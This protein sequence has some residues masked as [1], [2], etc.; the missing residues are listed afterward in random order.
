MHGSGA[1][2]ARAWS[3]RWVALIRFFLYL[4]LVGFLFQ[5]MYFGERTE[6]FRPVAALW[7]L[8]SFFLLS[9][10]VMAAGVRWRRVDAALAAAFVLDIANVTGIVA[11]S[12]GFNSVFFSLYLPLIFMASAW[13]P[14]R[15]TAVFPSVATLGLAYL[16]L[17]HLSDMLG[18]SSLSRFFR[19]GALI[20]ARQLEPF[21]VVSTLLIFSVLFFV[22]AYLAGMLGQGLF[23][24]QR[25]N[26]TILETMT[27][28]VAVVGKDG[29]M[30]YVNSE[31]RRI[32][33]AARPGGSF[34]PAAGALFSGGEGTER[35]FFG[36]MPKTEDAVVTLLPPDAPDRPPVEVR[37]SAIR[38]SEGKELDGL[39]FLVI[40]LSLRRRME[41][42]ESGLEKH[43]AIS[44]MAAGLAHEIRNPLASLRGA[45][46]ELGHSFS[47]SGDGEN[48]MLAEVVLTESDRLD[49]VVGR[50]LDFSRESRLRLSKNRL[51][52]LLDEVRTRLSR[53]GDGCSGVAVRVAVL[54][55]P[56]VNCDPDRLLEVFFNLAL[57]ACQLAPRS[58]GM[59]DITLRED[60]RPGRK[61]VE[62]LFED[63]GP[64]FA[65][66][67]RGRLF[68]PFFTGRSGGTGM[69]LAF[70]RK[71]AALHNGTI[72]GPG[73]GARFSVWLPLDLTDDSAV[74]GR[75]AHHGT[76]ILGS[77]L[78]EQ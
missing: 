41:R 75:R 60:D 62:I 57:N 65:E 9:L 77:M 51:S 69:G 72:E 4:I 64:G 6:F 7:L 28:G 78:P 20:S 68:A 29:R 1:A 37:V 45:V 11:S 49:N 53:A 50:F 8:A 61:G 47:C 40:D 3:M 16:S 70:S 31:F 59:L 63:N 25:L 34:F 21:T 38:L 13:L 67:D 48:R 15:F 5:L 56:E 76:R 2:T 55:D 19:V 17:G 54:D 52:A 74:G 33:P 44:A 26:E 39:L 23:V 66:K 14:R 32:F 27:E 10:A 36:A 24:Q 18:I 42:A 12:G 35:E 58:G 71:Q 30:V 43:L 22:V 46:Q 73:G